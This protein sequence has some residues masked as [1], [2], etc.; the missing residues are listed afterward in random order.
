MFRTTILLSF[1]LAALHAT[2]AFADDKPGCTDPQWAPKRLPGF[3]LSD[4]QTKPFAS[5]SVNLAKGAATL[6]GEVTTLNYTLTDEAK[7]PKAQAAR[8]YYAA[9]GTKFGAKVVS[10]PHDGYAVYLEKKSGKDDIYY[11]YDHGNGNE[12]VTGSYTLTTVKIAANTQ[13]VVAKKPAQPLPTYA[14]EGDKCQDPPWLVKNYPGFKLA[15]CYARDFDKVSFETTKGTKTFAG[16]VL[17][18]V[19]EAEDSDH[20]PTAI[21]VSTNFIGALT[22]IGAKL[23]TKKDDTY[24]VALEQ[25]MPKGEVWYL[26]QHG[27]GNEEVTGSFSLVTVE[28]G[29]PPTK[30]CKLEIYGV[31]FDTDKSTLRDDSTPVLEQLLAMFKADPKLS[32]ELSGHTDDR[33][34]DA[35]NQKL[36]EDRA[37]AVKAW[38]V[39]K[40]VAD[41]RI[42]TKGYGE[43][44][45]LVPNTSDQNRAKNR[46]TELLRNNCK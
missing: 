21:A 7:N 44:K 40:G 13:L 23:Q 20:T 11:L 26:Y 31:N 34:A 4:C 32:G 6:Q 18:H 15:R 22:K 9:A 30:A 17:E 25:K 35:Y 24:N 29:G 36:S 28:V 2:T 5:V 38:L 46:R 39:S 45:P 16:R 19:Y 37:A 43:T 27:N 33:G 12:D 42:T 10:D 3:E 41:A 8:D 14:S 1:S